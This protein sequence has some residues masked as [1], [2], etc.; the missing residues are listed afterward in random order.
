MS[1]ALEIFH[2][3]YVDKSQEYLTVLD[4]AN[5]LKSFLNSDIIQDEILKA[6]K[7]EAKSSDIQAIFSL[8]AQELGFASEKKGLFSNYLTAALRPDYYLQLSENTGIIMEVERGKTVL[9]NMDLLDVWKCHIC[10]Y[11]NY[12]F[13]VV[14]HMRHSGD[15]TSSSTYPKVV[16]R[17]HSFFV[18]GN[19][20]NVDAVFIF[21]Y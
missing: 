10:E 13:L 21:G 4:I 9:N 16:K 20:I 2:K 8:K 12:L 7:F 11:A 17:L 14:P 3:K 18:K 1:I 15:G 5:E 6:H 19:Y